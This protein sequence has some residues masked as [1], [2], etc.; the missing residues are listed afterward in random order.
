MEAT[1][2][3]Q[4][5]L[6]LPAVPS[7]VSKAIKRSIFFAA[8]GYVLYRF[9][10]DDALS[11]EQLGNTDITPLFGLQLFVVIFLMFVNWGIESL[12]WKMVVS[13]FAALSLAK[14]FQGVLFGLSVAI[15]TPNRS[16]EYFGRIWVIPHHA[17]VKSVVATIFAN[18]IQLSVTL[19]FGTIALVFWQQN[20]ALPF[21]FNPQKMQGYI[22]AILAIAVLTI[23]AWL[24]VKERIG[25][26][27]TYI[28][29]IF[30]E[31]KQTWNLSLIFQLWALSLLRYL[32]F[33]I[34]FWILLGIC[35]APVSLWETYV[36]IGIMYLVMALI[37]VLTLAEPAVR[38]TLCVVFLGV[39][40]GNEAGLICASII[41]WVINLAVPALVGALLLN[42]F[43]TKEY[44]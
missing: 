5:A 38:S 22:L 20:Y 15:F 30:H 19:I 27:K 26:Y 10:F 9:V 3:Q 28:R 12:K 8:W 35:L 23:V 6:G 11:F 7:L 17:R 31:I 36:G 43:K 33:M 39:Y 42:S 41:I 13:K 37:P 29:E 44:D 40:S 1:N 34:Q 21:N 24:F 16:G 25:K 4:Q 18:S 32:I 2:H 14:A